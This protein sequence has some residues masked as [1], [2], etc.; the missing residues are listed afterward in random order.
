MKRKLMLTLALAAATSASVAG[1][2]KPEMVVEY[3]QSMMTGL[4]WNMGGMGQMVK[5]EVPWD[6]KRFNYLATRTAMLAPMAREGFTPET[7]GVKSHA[8][9]EL[10]KNLKDFDARNETMLKA[11]AKLMEVAQGGNEEASRAQ[12]M[13]T[14]KACKGCHEKYQEKE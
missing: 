9:P 6:Q 11:A 3:R 4:A 14:V 7:E 1:G 10:W 2:P 12:F 13:E 8:K 5:G